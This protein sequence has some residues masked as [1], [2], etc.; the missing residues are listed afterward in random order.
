ML[1]IITVVVDTGKRGKTAMG[2]NPRGGSKRAASYTF[3]E[4]LQKLQS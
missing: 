3:K 1:A 2:L 4:A